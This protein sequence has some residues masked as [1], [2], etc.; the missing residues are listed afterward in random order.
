M[1]LA[2]F[3]ENTK[4]A[5]CAGAGGVGKTTTAA[6]LAAGMAQRG[7]RVLVLTIDPARRLAGALG[8]PETD[9]DEHAV[10]LA[11][12]GMAGTGTLHAAML[13]AQ[14][15]FDALVREQA[16]SEAA[17]DRILRNPIY[18]QLAGAV[19][20]SHEYMAME[21]LYEVWSSGRFDLIVLDTPPSRHALDFLEAPGRV[22]RFVDGRALRLLVRPGVRAGMLGM[23]VFGAGPNL[24]LAG[25]ERLTGM[26]FLADLSE[27][28]ASFEGM[29]EGFQRRAD[30]VSRLLASPETTFLLV[31]V[32]LTEPIIEADFFWRELRERDLP[33]G[34]V[35][36]NK[37][38]PSYVGGG[39]RGIGGRARRAL[40]EAGVP[41][42]AAARAAE[43]L[44]HFQ[45]LADRDRANI[46][47]LEERMGADAVVEVPLL[48]HDV[49]D[50]EGLAAVSRHLFAEV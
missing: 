27:F 36:M 10:D 13:D 29:Y 42:Q 48:E 47:R 6:A 28:L 30:E 50:L 20:G 17:A 41:E 40:H 32:P 3:M 38:H 11:A 12:H 19:A 5:V 33:F 7:R 39:R 14:R 46:E 31:T 35:V 18:Q 8:L 49:H 24:A 16:P 25:V 37:V 2:Q 26:T 34:G 15:T 22:T 9:D 44:L 45:S 21:R 1:N 23:R 4:V 43:N